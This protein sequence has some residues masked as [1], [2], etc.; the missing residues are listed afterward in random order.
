MQRRKLLATVGSL[1][2]GGAAAMGTGA[3]TSVSANRSVDVQVADD[4]VALLRLNATAGNRNSDYADESGNQISIDLTDGNSNLSENPSGVNKDAVTTIYD[5]FSIENQGTQAALVYVSPSSLKDDG[6]F[7]TSDDGVY[8]DPQ[9]SDAPNASSA[10]D[11]SSL[12][13]LGNGNN[14]GSLTGIGGSVDD[15]ET[16]VLDNNTTKV[17]NYGPDAYVLKPGEA[18]N[19]GLYIKT[20]DAAS[21]GTINYDMVIKADAELADQAGY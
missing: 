1:A 16:D 8:I 10:P 15:F 12:G 20:T 17:P 9:F 14:F 6:A 5:I 2:A 7:D 3:F 21:L 11:T 13:T 18:F 4:S 19:F